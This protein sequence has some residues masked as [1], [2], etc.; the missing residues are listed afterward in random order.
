MFIISISSGGPST[1]SKRHLCRGKLQKGGILV[2]N[3]E[4]YFWQITWQFYKQQYSSPNVAVRRQ[5]KFWKKYFGLQAKALISKCCWKTKNI[6]V[7]KYSGL[8]SKIYFVTKYS[9]LQAK[10]WA[11]ELISGQTRA[12]KI[13]VKYTILDLLHMRKIGVEMRK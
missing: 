3:T 6:F 11:G 8:Q 2:R 10:N 4:T 9:G 12:G 1:S 7:T 5:T 13:L